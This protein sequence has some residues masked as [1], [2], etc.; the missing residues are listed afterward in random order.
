MQ[1]GFTLDHARLLQAYEAA[2]ANS[3]Q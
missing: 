3:D 2:E 1:V